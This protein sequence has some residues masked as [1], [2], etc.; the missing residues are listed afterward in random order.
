MNH[1]A[2]IMYAQQRMREM[3]KK[4]NEYHFEP[5]RVSPKAIEQ[6]YGSITIVANNELYILISP[7]NHFG[8]VIYSDSN[9]FNADDAGASGVA[10]FAGNL[11]ILKT[12]VTWSL[13]NTTD[14][15]TGQAI[16]AKPLEFLRV[17]IY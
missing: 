16:K 13:Q 7:E 8:F 3:G 11:Y 6:T 17:V 2:A 1:Q 10:E 15:I 9:A 12:G 4:I 5:I 14:S